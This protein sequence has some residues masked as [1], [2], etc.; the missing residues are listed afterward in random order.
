M[1][2]PSTYGPTPDSA[3]PRVY[4]SPAQVA[5]LLGVPVKTI[6]TWT[7]ERTG[8]TFYKLGRHVRFIEADVHSWVD[9]R[10]A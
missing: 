10:A 5:E 3:A 2:K 6:Y 8:P 7:S 1:A 4:L 9:G